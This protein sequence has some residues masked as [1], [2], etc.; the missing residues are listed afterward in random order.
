MP[1]DG[2]GPPLSPSTSQQRDGLKMEELVEAIRADG[3]DL[4][5]PTIVALM[6]DVGHLVRLPA[7]RRYLLSPA[8]E[9]WGLGRNVRPK[10]GFPFPIIYPE[11]APMVARSLGWSWITQRAAS[12]VYTRSR[13]EFLVRHYNHL[14]VETLVRLSGSKKRTVELDL[15]RLRTAA[16]QRIADL[17][18]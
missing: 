12:F 9:H 16:D 4:D 3:V 5:R 14:P 8:A 10:R 7:Q 2:T 6:A 18:I 15:A 1:F 11:H 13:R 17:R